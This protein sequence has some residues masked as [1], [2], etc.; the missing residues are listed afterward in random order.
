MPS[1]HVLHN[2]IKL[3]KK[4]VMVFNLSCLKIWRCKVHVWEDRWAEEIAG[5]TQ[6]PHTA[7]SVG[8]RENRHG[9]W[10]ISLTVP[11]PNPDNAAEE[12]SKV[13]H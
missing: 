5:G 4:T 9:N 10:Q 2:Y 12:A 11:I 1:V 13:K 8:D 3:Q 6:P 7:Y